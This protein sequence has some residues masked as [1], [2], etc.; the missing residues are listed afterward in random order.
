MKIEFRF[1]KPFDE[2]DSTF[3]IVSADDLS[4]FQFE[5]R[6]EEANA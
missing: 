5:L 2:P 1:F 4:N 3:V 6:T